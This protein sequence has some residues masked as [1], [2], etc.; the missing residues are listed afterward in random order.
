MDFGHIHEYVQPGID[1]ESARLIFYDIY[2]HESALNEDVAYLKESPYLAKDVEVVGYL[3][4]LKSG[5][6]NKVA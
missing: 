3:Y 5:A 2:S 4:D 6:L 1:C